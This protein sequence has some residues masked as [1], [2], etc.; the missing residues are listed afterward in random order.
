MNNK[1]PQQDVEKQRKIAEVKTK[2]SNLTPAAAAEAASEVITTHA[3][4]QFRGFGDFLREQSVVGIGIGIVFGSQVKVVVDDIML[5]FVNPITELLLPGSAGLA[6]QQF[7]VSLS[8]K[9]ATIGWGAIVYSLLTF[10]MVA[11]IIYAA[12]KLLRLDK[13]KKDK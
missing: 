7:T 8:G 9:S 13:F 5:H 6:G 11:I 3:K 12:Y 4:K 10:I 1:T 2:L